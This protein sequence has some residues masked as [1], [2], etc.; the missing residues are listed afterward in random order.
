[1]TA[2][3]VVTA[4]PSD[5]PGQYVLRR[6]VPVAGE[7]VPDLVPAAVSPDL[8]VVRAA[9]PSGMRRITPIGADDPII[10]EWYADEDVWRRIEAA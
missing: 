9:V 10:L 4:N 8:E 7:L 6:H 5:Y 3:Y 1:M 2:F